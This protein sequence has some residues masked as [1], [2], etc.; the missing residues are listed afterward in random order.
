MDETKTPKSVDTGGSWRPDHTI[1]DGINR[2]LALWSKIYDA[3]QRRDVLQLAD[4]IATGLRDDQVHKLAYLDYDARA[5]FMDRLY[6][7]A[8]IRAHGD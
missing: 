1:I 6:A 2:R 7:D 3:G 5:T 8:L 4:E